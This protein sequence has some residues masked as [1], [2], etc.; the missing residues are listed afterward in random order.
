[1]PSGGTAELPGIHAATVKTGCIWTARDA[2]HAG[3]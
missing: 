1:M 3:L 2:A